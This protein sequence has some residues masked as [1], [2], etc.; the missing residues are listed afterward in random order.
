LAE[1]QFMLKVDQPGNIHI[2]HVVR[3]GLIVD[4]I[5]GVDIFRVYDNHRAGTNAFP[6]LP[7]EIGTVAARDRTD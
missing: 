4:R 5:A 2:K 1:A 3:P 7:I 6:H